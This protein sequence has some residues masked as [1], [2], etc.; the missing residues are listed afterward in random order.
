MRDEFA[1]VLKCPR[2]QKEEYVG[3]SQAVQRLAT[4]GMLKRQKEPSSELILELLQSARTQFACRA[5][6]HIGLLLEEE[7]GWDDATSRRNCEQCGAPI[8]P[9]R[10][11]IFPDVQ[12]CVA[13]QHGEESGDATE[14]AD[15]CPRCG[16]PMVVQARRGGITRYALVCPSCTRH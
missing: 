9:D 16:T 1:Y 10:L 3:L 8:D 11:E 13:C 14:E 12:L 4:V 2:C 7:V 15:Y 5:C 6:E